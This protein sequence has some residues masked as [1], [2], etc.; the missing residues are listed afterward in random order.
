M[1]QRFYHVFWLFIA[2]AYAP[3]VKADFSEQPLHHFFNSRL[4]KA[5]EAKLNL[6][7]IGSVEYGLSENLE[8]GTSVL[9]SI[10]SIPNFLLKHRMFILG[11][12][13][14]SF[15]SFTLIFPG[16][17]IG[18]KRFTGSASAQGVVTSYDVNSELS[19]N[20][21][22]MHAYS[23]LNTKN[24]SAGFGDVRTQVELEVYA[25]LVGLDYYL[26]SN[27]GVTAFV[28]IPFYANLNEIG[29][30]GDANASLFPNL[31]SYEQDNLVLFVSMTRTWEQF[32]FEF[33]VVN[34]AK[35]TFPYLAAYWR[36]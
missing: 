18:G 31:T 5:N 7:Y 3:W 25:A 13:E 30:F 10:G 35:T 2:V 26:S 6:N 29:D 8:V 11:P 21:G 27:W 24:Q 9:L 33:G 32:N 36:I 4:L 22:P 28:L 14:T 16:Q 23:L 15:T 19:L 20:V 12:T 1:M 34:F 17:Y